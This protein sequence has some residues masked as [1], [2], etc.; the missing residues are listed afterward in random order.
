MTLFMFLININV[1]IIINIKFSD[2]KTDPE[3]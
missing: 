3:A 2:P 1:T